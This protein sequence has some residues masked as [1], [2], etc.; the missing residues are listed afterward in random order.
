MKPILR[1]EKI[2]KYYPGVTALDSMDFTLN[3]G[4]V[5][6]LLGKNGAGKSTLV[7][8]LSGA[9]RPDSGKILIDD[10]HVTIDNPQNAFKKGISTV[11]Q[12]MSLVPELTVAENILL[13]RWARKNLFG[14]PV[15]DLKEIR[16]QARASID[17]LKVHLDLDALVSQL[18]IAEQQ[19]T[20]I[21]KAISYGPRVLILDEPTS[22]LPTE[23]VKIVHNVVRSLAEQGHSIIYVTHRLQEVPQVADSV[24]ILRDGMH[25]GTIPVSEASAA[26]IAQMMIGEDWQSEEFGKDIILGDVRLSVKHLNRKGVLHDISFE[27][28]GG[29]IL[30]IAGLLGSGRTE[31]VRAIFGSDPFEGGEIHL[32]GKVVTKPSPSSMKH[33]GLGVTPEDRRMQGFVPVFSVQKNLTLA[34]LER[35][36]RNGV[37]KP[38]IERSLAEKMVK[39]IDIKTAG[40]EVETGTLSG[41][42][43]QKVVIGNWLNTRPDVLI[44][45]EPTRGIDI[46][47]KEQIFSL[48]RDLAVEGMGILFISSEIEEIL[49]IADRILIMKDGRLTNELFPKDI[50]LEHLMALV[51]E[52]KINA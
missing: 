31:L 6:A 20:E 19:L 34:S 46:H 43:Q 22:A 28:R 2:T 23:E 38:K 16:R 51:M 12:E 33:L 30:G 7:K 21:A 36:S 5:R 27:I 3:K 49:N 48:M 11:Y 52:E 4:E 35:I 47:A 10:D 24:T 50:D 18:S 37:L 39:E 13:G 9:V 8:I 40:L 45:D 25:I 1:L 26:R 14:L 17:Q 15:I 42:N 32:K 29:E 41:G 44:M